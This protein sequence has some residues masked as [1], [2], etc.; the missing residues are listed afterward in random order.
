MAEVIGTALIAAFAHHPIQPA[1]RQRREHL[2]RLTDERQIRVDQ[3]FAWWSA[4]L[5]Q[6]SLCQHAPH[7]TV[8]DV[9]L[10]RDRADGPFFSVVEAQDLR[11][12]IRWYHR[13]RVLSD[14]VAQFLDD[15]GGDAEI[16]GG[17]DP[18]I[19]AR[20]SDSARPT[21]TVGQ[22]RRL[23]RSRS[24]TSW[25]LA[26]HP[27][28]GGVN[29]DA[30]LFCC[31]PGSDAPAQHGRAVQDGSFGSAVR[32][33][34]SCGGGPLAH[35]R[36]G[37]RFAHDRS[38]C[39][40]APGGDSLRTHRAGRIPRR[41]C[42]S[43]SHHVDER[44]DCRDTRPACVPGTV[45]GTASSVTAKFTSAPCLPL[46]QGKPLPALRSSASRRSSQPLGPQLSTNEPRQSR[47]PVVGFQLYMS[48]DLS[49]FRQP[50]T[51]P[52]ARLH[53]RR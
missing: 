28:G 10:P 17:R 5:W 3:R 42:R 7:H 37:N 15:G 36:R 35:N 6:T 53:C 31:A 2:Q 16:P 25:A 11:L 8:M 14:R 33:H 19:A 49:G 47:R 18:N 22:S 50:S 43:G 38:S 13:D 41:H 32:Q 45:W 40:S 24:P 39:R 46:D 51:R 1:G 26:D 52:Q 27:A 12:D 30:S 29:R 4:T 34:A 9:Q 20:T 48:P 44:H 23:R 21:A